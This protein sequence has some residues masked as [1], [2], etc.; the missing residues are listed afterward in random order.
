[1]AIRRSPGCVCCCESVE[2]RPEC[3]GYGYGG[4]DPAARNWTGWVNAPT[5]CDNVVP[6]DSTVTYTD[7]DYNAGSIVTFEVHSANAI[8]AKWTDGTRVVSVQ[9]IGGETGLLIDNVTCNFISEIDLTTTFTIVLN[10]C[11]REDHVSHKVD[12]LQAGETIGTACRRYPLNDSSS[13]FVATMK[14]GDAASI[15][16]GSVTLSASFTLDSSCPNNV[17]AWNN[18]PDGPLYFLTSVRIEVTGATDATV[19]RVEEKAY[20]CEQDDGGGFGGLEYHANKYTETTVETY[21][22]SESNG[23]HQAKLETVGD[24]PV[25]LTAQE[26][27]DFIQG[28]LDGTTCLGAVARWRLPAS[29]SQVERLVTYAYEDLGS[30]C[31][32]ISECVVPQVIPEKTDFS[33]LTPWNA[34]GTRYSGSP[35]LLLTIPDQADVT[36]GTA[37]TLTHLITSCDEPANTTAIYQ[38]NTE[39]ASPSTIDRSFLFGDCPSSTLTE[40]I[41]INSAGN[42]EITVQLIFEYVEI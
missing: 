20:G 28:V 14:G 27:I 23:T 2:L 30:I 37:P 40:T 24:P 39:T 36:S 31:G 42:S 13:A 21:P 22:N 4:S 25:E 8:G 34:L 38:G 29:F 15:T 35:L 17:C 1:V 19:T 12:I 33:E 7:I 26:Q 5:D 9:E 6:T 11:V 32:D 18:C 41:T 10:R 3:E 16:M